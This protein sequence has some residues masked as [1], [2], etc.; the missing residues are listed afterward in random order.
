MAVDVLLPGS[1]QTFT[2]ATE[3]DAAFVAA[4]IR[5]R[6][7]EGDGH[8]VLSLDDGALLVLHPSSTWFRLRTVPSRSG[9]REPGQADTHV[10][11]PA[12]ARA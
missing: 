8:V 3:G 12:S 7:A 9:A 6:A 2:I 4:E 1:G 5:K 10:R 11:P